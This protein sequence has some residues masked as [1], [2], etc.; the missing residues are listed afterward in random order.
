[1][2]ELYVGIV[3]G[4][5]L[6]GLD[7]ALVELGEDSCRVVRARTTPFPELLGDGLAALV[8]DPR[9]DLR[10]LG[11]LSVAFAEFAAECVLALLVDA[12]REPDEITAIGFSGHTVF[13]QPLPPRAFTLQ[14][15]D[16]S[17]IAART[18]ITTV[19][20]IRSMDVAL[21]G[22]GAPVLPAL[23]A[24][25]LGDAQEV[26]VVVNIGGIANLTCLNP[27][28]AVTGFDSGPGNA[29]MNAWC[30]LA[31]RGP[32]DRDGTWARS[33]SVITALLR[34]LRA[35]DYF[36]LPAPKSTG[37]EHFN[38]AWLQ[39]AVDETPNAAPADVQATLLEL[40]ATTIADAVKAGEPEARRVIVCGGGAYN[41]ALLERLEAL[42]APTIVET[43]AV[44][45]I[46]PEWVETAGFAWLA[47]ARLQGNAGNLP[48]VTGAREP[49]L[50]GGVYSGKAPNA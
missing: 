41:A 9:T 45:G 11:T 46:E 36:P 24:W 1:M 35:D 40:T 13:H 39:R 31:D 20:D 42:L 44:H 7:T 10:E 17:T 21:G 29:L 26:R 27:G 18:R 12:E 32:F 33:G 19:A 3:S 50:L 30:R 16:P 2:A 38:I 14:L 6:D 23:H 47:R 49:A 34:R 22:Q 15:G 37:L 48:S 8:T 43:S 4:T 25:Q 28:R 5:S